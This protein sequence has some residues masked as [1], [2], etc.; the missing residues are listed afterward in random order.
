MQPRRASERPV[1]ALRVE[2]LER[3]RADCDVLR[4]NDF[5]VTFS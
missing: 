3:L 1:S 4:Y 2:Q 5:L